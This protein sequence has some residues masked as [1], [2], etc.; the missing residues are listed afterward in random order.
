MRLI[1]E[2]QYEGRKLADHSTI[3][4]SAPSYGNVGQLAVDIILSTLAGNAS[5]ERL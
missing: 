3:L 1:F 5:K 4:L 2:N